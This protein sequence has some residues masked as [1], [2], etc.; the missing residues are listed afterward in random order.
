MRAILA[1]LES[2]PDREVVELARALGISQW[3]QSWHNLLATLARMESRCLVEVVSK[4][5]PDPYWPETLSIDVL[6][7]R[8]LAEKPTAAM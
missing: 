8:L 1:D 4:R 2:E 3:T 7:V 6:T 5:K